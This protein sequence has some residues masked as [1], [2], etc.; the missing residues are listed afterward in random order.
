MAKAGIFSNS[1]FYFT[2]DQEGQFTAPKDLPRHTLMMIANHDVATF[3]AWWHESDLEQ[4][5]Q[6]QLFIS[7]DSCAQAKRQRQ[8]DKSNLLIWLAKYSTGK[9]ALHVESD[10]KLIYQ[11]LTL[12]L[13]SS[14]VELLT[15]QLDD[16][17]DEYLPVNIPGTDQE[18]PNWRRRLSKNSKQ[19]LAN[20]VFFS[21]L[22]NTRK[23]IKLTIT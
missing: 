8:Q 19:L 6:L 4:R 21:Q 17:A 2:K 23:Q 10:A 12:V 3:N 9:A 22:T 16:L 20:E 1:L 18:Y 15:L 7:S 13:A 11:A 5:Q 14:H